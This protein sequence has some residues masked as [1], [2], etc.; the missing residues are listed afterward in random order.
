MRKHT[1]LSPGAIAGIVLA[2]AAVAIVGHLVI[3]TVY[4]ACL[5]NAYKEKG[6]EEGRRTGIIEG[7][8]K[9]K[10]EVTD[11]VKE[12]AIEKGKVWRKV[13]KLAHKTT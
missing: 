10:Q 7:V 11:K 3:F 1:V 4:C 8:E 2:S 9:G 13:G 5:R 6:R 12:E